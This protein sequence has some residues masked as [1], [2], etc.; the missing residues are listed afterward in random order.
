MRL[1][2]AIDKPGEIKPPVII[3]GGRT[4]A[5]QERLRDNPHYV[6]PDK[7]APYGRYTGRPMIGHDMQ[8]IIGGVYLGAGAREAIVVD[9][10]GSDQ[11]S[12]F[13]KQV[14]EEKVLQ[15]LT[16]LAES[17]S[18]EALLRFIY[19]TTLSVFG[20]STV[21]QTN[22]LV[23]RL[24]G[25]EKDRKVHLASFVLNK[26]GVCRHRALFAGYLIEKLTNDPK[27]PVKLDGTFSIERNTVPQFMD[28]YKTNAHAWVRYTSA[29]GDPWIIDASL[30]CFGRLAELKNRP[31]LPWEYKRQGE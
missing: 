9:D 12:L 5:L 1:T 19:L 25:G 20:N 21:E 26:I 28:I 10:T 7:D 16:R 4:V 14:Y 18:T 23:Q 31:N 15:P 24:T 30:K 22:D 27:S 6:V 2:E 17:M 11:S 13:L 3:E 8:H 29:A